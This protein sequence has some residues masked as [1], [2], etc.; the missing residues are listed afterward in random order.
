MKLNLDMAKK[1]LDWHTLATNLLVASYGNLFHQMKLNLDMAKK[2]LD[3][4]TLAATRKSQPVLKHLS[5]PRYHFTTKETVYQV[6][7]L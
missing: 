6:Y 7:D 5:L 4:H 2:R 1:R 3:W